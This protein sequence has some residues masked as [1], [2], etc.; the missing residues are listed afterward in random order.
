MAVSFPTELENVPYTTINSKVSVAVNKNQIDVLKARDEY[1]L[2]ILSRF[3]AI[4]LGMVLPT[5]IKY[6]SSA[7]LPDGWIFADGAIYSK[8]GEMKDLWE[9]IQAQALTKT[10][11]LANVEASVGKYVDMENGTFK[12]PNLDG[13]FIMGTNTT[14]NVGV[15]GKDQIKSH[16]HDITTFAVNGID[17]NNNANNFGVALVDKIPITGNVPSAYATKPE[18]PVVDE[19]RPK[20][21]SY[22]YMIKA[23]FT[24]LLSGDNI[25]TDSDAVQ[26]YEPKLVPTPNAIPVSKENGKIDAGWVD[27]SEIAVNVASEVLPLVVDQIG[28]MYILSE[29]ATLESNANKIPKSDD[30]GKISPSWIKFATSEQIKSLFS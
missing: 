13:L 18:S 9:A 10:E 23:T 27:F 4:P 12:V 3:D 5:T 19:T 2:N 26:G 16:T 15:F 21:V 1:T 24:D 14:N 30:N 28:D 25:Y 22:R 29:N 20:N 7:E 8:T 17:V 6:G 11:Y